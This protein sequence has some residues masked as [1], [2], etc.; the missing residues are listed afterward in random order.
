MIDSILNL[1][2]A[3]DN[4]YRHSI[5]YAWKRGDHPEAHRLWHELNGLRR[6]RNLIEV[7][8]VVRVWKGM[9]A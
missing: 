7:Y 6:A 9:A 3:E 4:E 5:F 2:E 1:I 8:Q